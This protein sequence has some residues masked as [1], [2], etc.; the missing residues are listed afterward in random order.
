MWSRLFCMAL[1]ILA[2]ERAMAQDSVAQFYHGRE[3]LQA[4]AEKIFTTPASVVEQAKQV[5][6]KAPQ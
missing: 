5:E 2:S 3:Q 1:A 4:L 6:Y